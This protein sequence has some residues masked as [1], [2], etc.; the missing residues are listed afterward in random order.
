MKQLP[1]GSMMELIESETG[2]RTVLIP[3]AKFN[4]KMD[5]PAPIAK[6]GTVQWYV[7]YT[8]VHPLTVDGAPKDA[9]WINVSSSPNAYY[10]ALFDIW[11]RGESF[12]VLEHDVVCRPDVIESFENCPEPWCAYGYGD[13]CHW[14]C[15]EAWANALGCTRFR[16]EALEAVPDA[17]SSVPSHLWDWHQVCDR[18]G[19][20]LRAAGFRHHWHW[21]PVVHHHLVDGIHGPQPLIEEYAE[22]QQEASALAARR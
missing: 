15:M 4:G 12:A 13:I 16:Q 21:P 6:Q 20:R 2:N 22:A 1:D 9:I 19:E 14:S 3:R 10:A 18:L 7:P 8:A 17:L 11:D 5:P